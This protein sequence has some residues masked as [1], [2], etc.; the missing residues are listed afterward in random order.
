MK[1]NDGSGT[2]TGYFS[3]GGKKTVCEAEL[4]WSEEA[5]G[6]WRFRGSGVD[7]GGAEFE[8]AGTAELA[9]PCRVQ[10]TRAEAGQQPTRGEGFR[11]K[12]C[13]NMFGS[14]GGSFSLRQT[15]EGP[16]LRPQMRAKLFQVRRSWCVSPLSLLGGRIL[17]FLP[18]Y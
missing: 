12:A 10:L 14:C 16:K 7:A 13:F 17:L 1:A 18:V 2:Y 3:L 6:M 4:Q 11:E 9:A 5:A 8:L 15:A